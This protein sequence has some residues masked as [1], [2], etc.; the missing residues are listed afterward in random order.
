M[1]KV[2][3]FFMVHESC[4]KVPGCGP[5]LRLQIHSRD[6]KQSVNVNFKAFA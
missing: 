2:P 3:K 6:G 1:I 4:G 5:V